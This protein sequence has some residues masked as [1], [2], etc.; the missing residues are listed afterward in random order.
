MQGELTDFNARLRRCY[1][2]WLSIPVR[3]GD[4]DVMGHVNNAMIATYFEHARCSLIIPE[5]LPATRGELN[6]V[7]ARIIIDYVREI[8]FPGVVE[9]GARLT[10]IGTKS[11][12]IASGAF[13]GQSCCATAEATLVF[14]DTRTRTATSPTGEVRARLE[15]LLK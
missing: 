8:R 10:R 13:V 11:F 4:Q 12:T 14:F 2:A 5:I 1:G 3:F 6:V 15:A 9:M 7:L